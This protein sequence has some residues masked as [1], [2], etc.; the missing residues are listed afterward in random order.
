MCTPPPLIRLERD[1]AVLAPWAVHFLVSE[2]FQVLAQSLSCHCRVKDIIDEAT[3]RS[4]HGI[5][6]SE[7][8]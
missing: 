4:H 6:E 7:S 1:V 8:R 2:E 5:G 3:F